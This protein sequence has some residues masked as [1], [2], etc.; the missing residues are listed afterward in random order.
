[1]ESQAVDPFAGLT[2]LL[3][4]CLM[5]CVCAHTGV[6]RTAREHLAAALAL[7]IP[8][9]A[10]VTKTDQADEE[11]LA[12]T[13]LEARLLLATAADTAT[14]APVVRAGLAGHTTDD[15]TDV[16]FS[17]AADLDGGV[18]TTDDDVARNAERKTQVSQHSASYVL[19]M[20][21]SS[22]CCVCIVQYPCSRQ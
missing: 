20:N 22:Q 11:M 3:P 17:M 15:T 2:S 9:F 7:D 8:V 5:F 4:D 13:L 1:M 21:L 18:F 6:N 12:S 16:E 19:Q 14:A 10:V